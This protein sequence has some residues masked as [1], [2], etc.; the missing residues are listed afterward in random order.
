MHSASI[1]YLYLVTYLLHSYQV[2]RVKQRI[3]PLVLGV[4]LLLLGVGVVGYCIYLAYVAY[5][6][7]KPVLPAARSLDEAITNT[8]YE[9]LNLVL[10]LGFLGIMVWAGGLLLKH[11]AGMIVD[12]HR[13][14]KGVE[15]CM[16]Q[17]KRVSQ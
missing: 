8:A 5:E 12:I 10:K 17:S 1:S 6:T 7:Y 4:I 15:K 11:G 14:E 9:L 2:E 13:A 16:E 3:H